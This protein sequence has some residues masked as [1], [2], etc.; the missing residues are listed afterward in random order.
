VVYPLQRDIPL[1]CENALKVVYDHGPVQG[2]WDSFDTIKERVE[3]QWNALGKS[4][5]DPISE[6]LKR[7]IKE[8][9]SST[10]KDN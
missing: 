2:C 6:A 3:K 8:C 5:R 9:S 4:F 1:K 10:T 7:K